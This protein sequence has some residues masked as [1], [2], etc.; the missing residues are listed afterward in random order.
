MHKHSE[1]GLTLVE[2]MVA[3]AVLS[4]A[5]MGTFNVW[6]NSERLSSISREEAIAHAAIN[7]ILSRIRATSFQQITNS[8]NDPTSPGFSG[9]DDSNTEF[10][11]LPGQ[12]PAR[13]G[14][15]LLP[16]G[17]RVSTTPFTG[18]FAMG[19]RY[20]GPDNTIA[21]LRV[22][23]INNEN[24]IEEQLGEIAG[25]K[26]GIDMNRDGT[27]SS[28]PFPANNPPE[29]DVF[30]D[31]GSVPL[32][33][34]KLASGTSGTQNAWLNSSQLVVLPVAVQVRWWSK[35]GMPLEITVVTFLTNRS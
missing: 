31:T 8:Q 18:S 20:Y 3:C 6:M 19:D 7:D 34:R 10:R 25:N 24:P 14:S 29:Y 9:G 16:H 5:L 17:L 27:I 1:A 30:P 15:D 21:E 13:V 32:F 33:P 22:I 23:F 28:Q 35:A 26:D 11:L 2:V 12:F 4:V